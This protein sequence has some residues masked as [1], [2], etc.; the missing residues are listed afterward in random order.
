MRSQRQEKQHVT[1][2]CVKVGTLSNE[3]M[4]PDPFKWPDPAS[5]TETSPLPQIKELGVSD[6]GEGPH[7]TQTEASGT[8]TS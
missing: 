2:T 4:V 7:G 6:G 1:R 5:K 3:L 8:S